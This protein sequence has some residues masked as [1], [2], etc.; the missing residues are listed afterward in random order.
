MDQQDLNTIFNLER[1]K[2][3]SYNQR[4]D[5][6]VASGLVRDEGQLNPHGAFCVTTGSHTGRSANDK[7]IVE[8]ELTAE[9]VWWA[10]NKKMSAANFET[11]LEDF[12]ALI[13]TKDLFVQDLYAGAQV[14]HQSCVRIV[15]QYAWHALFIRNLLI[16]PAAGALADFS[17]DMTIISLPDFKADPARHG[18]TSS[19]VIACDFSRRIILIGGTR[20]AGEIKK[21]VFTLFNFHAPQSDILPMHCAANVS[22]SGETSL[23]FGLSGTGKTTLSTD[24]Q[25][26]LVGDDEHGWSKDGVFNLEG[27]CYAKA[28]NLTRQAEPEI[29]DASHKFGAVLENVVHNQET[30]QPDF[31]DDSLTENTRCAYPLYHLAN[32]SRSGRA[33]TPR[34]VILLTADAFGVLPPI[35]RLNNTQALYHFLSG[36]TAKLAGT[37]N[38]IKQPQATFSPCFGGP[39]MPRH[40]MAYGDLF[41][42]L[43][44]KNYTNVWLLNTGWT[45]GPYG[46]GKRMPLAQTRTMLNAAL[47]GLLQSTPMR[48]DPLFGF[49]VPEKINAVA[50]TLLDPRA[51]WHDGDAYDRQGQ[52]LVALFRSNFDI[53]KDRTDPA[54]LAGGPVADQSGSAMAAAE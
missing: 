11:L 2:S 27:G 31:A 28:I 50:P 52:K 10:A 37:E 53:F 45:G 1:A 49:E 18:T 46:I 7:F 25:R 12:K 38:G 48:L 4:V 22:A 21:A 24:A 35:A 9:T 42:S 13:P 47:D 5:Q 14:E 32:A 3:V 8:D 43:L 51:S 54:V 23:F 34:T 33:P 19:T 29:F 6:L 39:F 40:P 41:K 20:Y 44:A 26:T 17:A 15:T 36:Y 30:G 16:R